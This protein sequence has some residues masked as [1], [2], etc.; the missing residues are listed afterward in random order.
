MKRVLCLYFPHLATDRR[1][2]SGKRGGNSTESEGATNPREPV[3]HR[4]TAGDSA[5]PEHS[6][7][8]EPAAQCVVTF[9][10][11]GRTAC[12]VHVDQKAAAVGIFRGQTVA[13]AQAMVP[14][15][16][17]VRDDPQADRRALESLAIRADRFSPVVAL[18][19]EDALLID[20]T[21]CAQL[22]GGEEN[23]VAQA[24]RG[25][26]ELG[27][28]VRCALADTPGAARALAHAHHEDVVIA[29]PGESV[30]HLAPLPVWSL[31]LDDSVV[32]MLARVG[33]ETIE[34]LLH[35]PR[36]SLSQRFGASLLQ[37]L[38]KALGNVPEPLT[39]YRCSPVLSSRVNFAPS[40]RIEVL[41]EAL[42]R[43]TED[44]C[45]RLNRQVAGVQRVFVTLHC[46]DELSDETKPATFFV[47]LS[48]PTRHTRHLQSLLWARL[49]NAL[50]PEKVCG[51]TLWVRQIEALQDEQDFLFEME[52]SGSRSVDRLT[53]RLASR[54]GWDAVV[55]PQL[56]PDHQPE[57]AFRW[58]SLR[59]GA[60]KKAVADSEDSRRR[61]PAAQ[62][63]EGRIAVKDRPPVRPLRLSVRP[64]P[65]AVVSVVPSGP[66]ISM[67]VQ[68]SSVGIAYREGP[69]RIETGWWR[70]PHVQRDY[71]R[72]ITEKG[73]R[74]W[75]FRDR[76]TGRWFLHGWFD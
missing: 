10:E 74:L 44:L 11:D 28:D 71:Y 70:G 19:G 17:L 47:D 7:R 54:L 15:L 51:L 20:V 5:S 49:E 55:Q 38:D 45:A 2:A 26:Q 18:E 57:C 30:R 73:V 65:I 64:I 46:L 9:T 1:R 50:R 34:A 14:G 16:Q 27:F 36:S 31:R 23:L 37:Q 3:W 69:E 41:R 13:D 25:V 63:M 29:A 76:L 6:R 59:Q 33:V 32:T 67:R 8:L 72:V 48:R 58:V 24:R 39:P 4:L 60:A 35:L 12:V 68:G 53:D 43:T 21:G 22:F 75:V 40:T 66:P 42:D 56:E 62:G 52:C 61:K